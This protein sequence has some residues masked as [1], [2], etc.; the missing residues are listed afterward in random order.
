MIKKIWK[1]FESRNDEPYFM[2][3]GIGGSKKVT[4][5]QTLKC[6]KKRVRGGSGKRWYKSGFHVYENLDILQKFLKTLKINLDTRFIVEVYATNPR[7]KHERSKA[8][9]ADEL[10]VTKK[11]WA[12]RVSIKEFQ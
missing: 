1:V 2:F 10:I 8:H 5:N 9:L 7:K 12:N 6:D 11:A 3:Y 4:L